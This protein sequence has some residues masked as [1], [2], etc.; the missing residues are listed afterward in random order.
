MKTSPPIV[1]APSAAKSSMTR[2]GA[3]GRITP[4]VVRVFAATHAR[5]FANDSWV[6]VAPMGV[7]QHIPAFRR[8]HGEAVLRRLR[9]RFCFH[10]RPTGHPSFFFANG[11]A[12]AAAGLCEVAVDAL[13]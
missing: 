10:R 4:A 11:T 9:C 13:R 5:D 12:Y 7:C 1:L 3:R 2:A 8:G 6:S